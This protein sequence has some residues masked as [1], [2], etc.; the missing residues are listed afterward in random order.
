[1][2]LSVRLT[3]D[4]GGVPTSPKP[5]KAAG[6]NLAGLRIQKGLTQEKAAEKI[7]ISLKYYQALEGGLKAP[8]FTT[9]CK[10]RRAVSATWDE[11]LRGC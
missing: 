5:F 7:G 1:M 11:F 3:F 4:H 10:V 6:K 2:V 8:A 9:L